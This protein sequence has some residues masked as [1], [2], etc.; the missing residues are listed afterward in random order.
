M[1]VISTR[2]EWDRPLFAGGCHRAQ[3][4]LADEPHGLCGI[5]ISQ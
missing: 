5:M 1:N 4:L 3:G 2:Q